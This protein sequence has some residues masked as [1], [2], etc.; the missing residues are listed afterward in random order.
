MLRN[1]YILPDALEPNIA[2]LEQL[3]LVGKVAQERQEMGI[4]EFTK[5]CFGN[6]FDSEVVAARYKML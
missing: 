3:K 5:L 1:P 6:K 2:C 4:K